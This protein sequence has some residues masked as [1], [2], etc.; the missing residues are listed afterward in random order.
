MPAEPFSLYIHWPFCPYRCSYCPFI[1]LAGQDEQMLVYHRALV[2]EVKQWALKNANRAIRTIYFG[3]GTPS[4]YPDDLLLDMSGTLKDVFDAHALEEVTLEVNPGTV[5]QKQL[6]VWSK[7]GIN[8]LSIGVQSLQDAQLEAL[9]RGHTC[10]QATDLLAYAS[11]FFDNISIDLM[12]GLPGMTTEQWRS[13]LQKVID[14]PITH[15]SIYCLQLHELTPLYY[16]IQRGEMVLPHDDMVAEWYSWAIDFLARHGFLQYEVSN[17]SRV[18]YES[19]HN[20]VYWER[21]PYKGIGLAACSFE[22]DERTQNESSLMNYLNMVGK[23]AE[24]IVFS[25]I[26]AAETIRLEKIMLGLRRTCGISRELI[27]EGLSASR[28]ADLAVKID[29]L[30]RQG[31]MCER[32]GKLMLTCA[33]FVVENEIVSEII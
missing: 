19:K 6:E 30:I 7:A 5:K 3:G 18:Q 25:E 13:D 4:T 9:N 33:G 12:I 28:R 26:L 27:V 21:K 14:W 20:T 23:G 32:D 22:N 1:A 11:Q 31:F 10:K 24:P 17:F 2:S 8:R 29:N 15:I 16:K